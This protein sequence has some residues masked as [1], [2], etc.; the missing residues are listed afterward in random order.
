ML[1]ISIY[2]CELN[3]HG[4]CSVHKLADLASVSKNIAW[5]ATNLV[6]PT[7]QLRVHGYK[8]VGSLTRMTMQHNYFIF[9]LYLDNPSMP[10]DG[11]VEE[12]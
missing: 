3:S 1:V 8:F 2:D 11:Y 4:Q 12:S 6:I 9:T 7:E 5:Q 10:L